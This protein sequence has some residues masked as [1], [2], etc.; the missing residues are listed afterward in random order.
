MFSKFIITVF[1]IVVAFIVLRQRSSNQGKN[2]Q[3]AKTS[4]TPKPNGAISKGTEKDL[5][6][7]DMRLGAYLFLLLTAGIGGAMY[8]FQW[9]DDHSVLTINLYRDSQIEPVSYDVYKYQLREKSFVTIG[10]LSVAVASSERMEII[11]LE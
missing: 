8:Y 6:S 10:G 4:Q 1:V 3:R 9:Q 11:G 7:R 5:L 2:N